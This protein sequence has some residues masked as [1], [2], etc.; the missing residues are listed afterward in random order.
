MLQKLKIVD[1]RLH[2]NRLAQPLM[3]GVLLVCLPTCIIAGDDLRIR[4]STPNNG[5]IRSHATLPIEVDIKWNNDRLL[6][7]YV[8]IRFREASKSV[9]E[10]QTFYTYRTPDLALSFGEKKLGALLP[11]AA[12]K[13]EP[14]GIL[15]FDVKFVGTDET[16]DLG[17]STLITPTIH[18]QRLL[19]GVV[20]SDP[21]IP[22]ERT[23]FVAP[24]HFKTVFTNKSLQDI[25]SD[26]TLG[27][28]M[29][30]P[31]LKINIFYNVSKEAK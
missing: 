29:F 12:L 2:L 16:I 7:G 19:I 1:F 10:Q 22:E 24:L 23:P 17:S 28:A 26:S 15:T 8:E 4:I 11:T 20:L 13:Q 9:T 31:S 3:A 14:G 25:S 5:R 21:T 6:E 18:E 27:C 30:L